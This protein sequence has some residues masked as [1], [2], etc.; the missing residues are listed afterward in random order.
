V[1]LDRLARIVFSLGLCM[2]TG[3][4]KPARIPFKAPPGLQPS[5]VEA[6]D[7]LHWVAS[8]QRF[9]ISFFPLNPCKSTDNLVNSDG[10]TDIVCHVRT[11]FTG[12]YSYSYIDPR[13]KSDKSDP[14]LPTPGDYPLHVGPCTACVG[15]DGSNQS[16]TNTANVAAGQT[17]PTTQEVTIYCAGDNPAAYP[18]NA[19]AN[20]VIFE[21]Q[22]QLPPPGSKDP[23]F[24]VTFGPNVCSNHAAGATLYTQGDSCD[25]EKT[26][27][28][29]VTDVY[30]G[31]NAGEIS[32]TASPP[33]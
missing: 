16:G 1:K 17:T 10:K 8:G 26:F 4:P 29:K 22:G 19:T 21:F 23:L 33:Q 32:G 13:D 14:K 20:T 11:E 30:G 12:N 27:T 5:Y 9:Q 31:C 25:V 2:L 15:S 3:C 7:V 28:Y 6:G 18:A 24:N